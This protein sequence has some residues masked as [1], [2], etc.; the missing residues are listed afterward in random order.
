MEK[1][2]VFGDFNWL[3]EPELIGELCYEKL[4]GS[5]SY[6]FKFDNNWLNLHAGIKLSEDINNYPGMQYTLPGNDIF[7]CFSDALPDRWGRTLL[8]RRE[9]LQ[10]EEE[11]RAPRS[12]SSFDYLVGIDDFSRM[13]GFRFKKEING[14]FINVSPSLKIPPLTEIRELIYASQEIEKCE[15]ENILPEKKWIAQ[16]IQPGTSLGGARPKAGVLDEDGKLC[17]AKFSSRNDDYDAGLWEHFS[18]LLAKKA[19]IHAAETRVLGG[20]GK[21]HTLLSKRFDRTDEG[22]RI[23]FAS[24][25]S[26]LGL[27][28]GDNA[29]GGYGYLDIVDFILQ[30]CCNVEQNLQEL[31]RRVAFNICIGNSDD[32]FRNH[33]FLLTSKGWTLSPAYDMNPTNNV[34]QSLLINESSNKADIQMLLDACEDYMINQKVAQGIIKDVQAAVSNWETLARQLQIP[35]RE[36]YMFKERFKLN[37]NY[38]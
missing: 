38:N 18:H 30:G 15:V 7:G 31:Y 16:L 22:K 1:L 29:Q 36:Q 8:K 6:A 11:K 5:D 37:L 27:K 12:L 35:Q 10:A 33:G 3:H 9:Q 23:H 4:R 13:G 32:H 21:Y 2:F 28:D 14:E 34:Y 24:S 20:L 17:I 25:M 19:G 26:L